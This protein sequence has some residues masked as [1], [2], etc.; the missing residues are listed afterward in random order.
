MSP[1]DSDLLQLVRTGRSDAFDV[2]VDRYRPR[3]LRF[4]TQMFG[5]SAIA[6]DLVQETFAAVFTA[7]D[8]FNP[9]FA[10]STWIWTILLNVCRRERRRRRTHQ[11]TCTEAAK[12]RDVSVAHDASTEYE[13]REDA[14]RL[15][16]LLEELPAAQAD[17]LR[18]RFFGGLSF[19]EVALAMDSSVSGAKVRVRKGLTA[20]A[21][22][23]RAEGTAE[24]AHLL[25]CETDS[26]SRT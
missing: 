7:R 5:E 14:A 9:A 4:A 2:L 11:R 18:L 19:D 23:L 15:R 10:F 24:F 6:E 3:L 25:R 21:S 17:A 22:R 26:E 1:S 12:L 8:S 16:T 13:R 20:M